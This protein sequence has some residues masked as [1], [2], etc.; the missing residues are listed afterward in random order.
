MSELKYLLESHLAAL[1][2][3]QK[4]LAREKGCLLEGGADGISQLAADKERALGK[5]TE[6]MQDLEKYLAPEQGEAASDAFERSIE[7]SPNAGELTELRDRIKD[8]LRACAEINQ[9]NGAILQ[10]SRSA[11]ERALRVL[12]S[13][14]SIP[15]RYGATGQLE[16]A[17]S[18][19]SIGRA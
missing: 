11:S 4:L 13:T 3:I 15:H 1:V 2:D 10:H 5:A 16:N 18:R 9:S 12:L 7:C 6:A 8:A 17:G 14:Q 19:Q